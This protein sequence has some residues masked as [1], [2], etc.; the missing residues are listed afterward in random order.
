MFQQGGILKHLIVLTAL[1]TCGNAVYA[2]DEMKCTSTCQ[3]KNTTTNIFLEI[4]EFKYSCHSHDLQLAKICAEKLCPS[5]TEVK[6]TE[7]HHRY[8]GKSVPV[9]IEKLEPNYKITNSIILSEINW[10]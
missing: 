8:K 7:C 10:K 6:L 1:T 5:G 3:P 2:L 9:Q 4:K